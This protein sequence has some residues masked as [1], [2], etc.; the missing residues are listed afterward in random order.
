MYDMHAERVILME[1][2]RINCIRELETPFKIGFKK[3][4][5]ANHLCQGVFQPDESEGEWQRRFLIPTIYSECYSVKSIKCSPQAIGNKKV[6][7]RNR[8]ILKI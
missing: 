5:V 6:V 4:L 8:I 7:N 2:T 3:N 1:L